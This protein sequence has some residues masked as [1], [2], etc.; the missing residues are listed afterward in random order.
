MLG[1]G[2]CKCW[3]IS[4]IVTG[5]YS[6]PLVIAVADNI[7]IGNRIWCLT[8]YVYVLELSMTCARWLLRGAKCHMSWNPIGIGINN[9][10]PTFQ[11]YYQCPQ[12]QTEN[13]T[14]A[15]RNSQIKSERQWQRRWRLRHTHTHT[16]TL[17]ISKCN[18]FLWMPRWPHLLLLKELILLT[19]SK[20]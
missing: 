3:K 12:L 15:K 6:F 7:V 16:H 1:Y 20:N 11:P 14:N 5:K 19:L 8:W 4:C 10:H 9:V 13:V 17:E 2:V 18:F